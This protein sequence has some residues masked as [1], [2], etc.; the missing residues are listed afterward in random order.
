MKIKSKR[1]LVAYVSIFVCITAILVLV[2]TNKQYTIEI[3]NI[4]GATSIDGESYIKLADIGDITYYNVLIYYNNIEDLQNNYN[5]MEI[6]NYYSQGLN[7]V[8][9]GTQINCEVIEKNRQYFIL[10]YYG[11]GITSEN[12]SYIVDDYWKINMDDLW[13]GKPTK[14]SNVTSNFIDNHVVPN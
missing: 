1:C 2:I 5:S 3:R 4:P 6:V 9:K 8:G 14:I 13:S 12:V 7:Y 10:H 11:Q